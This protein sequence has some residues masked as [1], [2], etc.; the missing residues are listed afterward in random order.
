V[1][2]PEGDLAGP[3]PC[4]PPEPRAEPEA[5]PDV[6]TRLLEAAY[7]CIAERGIGAT[8]LEEVAR[9]AGVSRATLYRYFPGGRDELVAAVVTNET[10]RFF[11]RLAEAVEG[12]RDVESLLVDGIHFA[13]LAIEGHALLQRLLG[14]EP[15]RLLPHLSLEAAWVLGLITAFF[16]DRLSGYELAEGVAV[17]EAAEYVARLTLSFIEAPGGWDLADREQVR[18]LVRSELLAG[19][20]RRPQR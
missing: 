12:A 15:E 10:L 14:T 6:R 18:E 19:L 4:G 5:G 20:Q 9:G 1:T 2:R 17:P 3:G 13:H 8:S 11:Q 16:E 7:R